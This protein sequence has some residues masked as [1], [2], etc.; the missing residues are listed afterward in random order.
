M[1]ISTSISRD[2]RLRD[3][4][5]FSRAASQRW[6]PASARYYSGPS[7]ANASYRSKSPHG[8]NSLF[9]FRN[10][11]NKLFLVRLNDHLEIRKSLSESGKR[12]SSARWNGE[13]NRVAIG[14]ANGEANSL[15]NGGGNA[16]E[17]KEKKEIKGNEIKENKESET[18]FFSLE[19]IFLEMDKEK[20]LKR[21]FFKR[22]AEIHALPD[23]S[24]KESF[25][26]WAVLKE[27][28]AMTVQKAEN[29]FNLFLLNNKKSYISQPKESKTENI[30]DEI[31]KD[32]NTK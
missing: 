13:A 12:G 20:P 26:R 21:P 6:G 8:Y 32:L 17:R 29:S 11:R 3:L 22:M 16:K 27:G 14:V 5:V 25:N 4:L 18:A 31:A 2:G 9:S 7:Y 23:A 1:F 24:V 15:A 19:D 10:R 28:E 30:W